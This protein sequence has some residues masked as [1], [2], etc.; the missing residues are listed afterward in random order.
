MLV[1]IQTRRVSLSLT[2]MLVR[3]SRRRRGRHVSHAR[4]HGEGM[5]IVAIVR[6]KPLNTILILVSRH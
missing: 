4:V 3:L 1:I 5:V 6:V 2:R